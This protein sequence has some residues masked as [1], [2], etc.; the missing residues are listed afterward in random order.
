MDFSWVGPVA[1][2]GVGGLFA[3]LAALSTNS[4]ALRM[5]KR[6]EARADRENL[7]SRAMDVL[8][9]I[10][11]F[12]ERRADAVGDRKLQHD[13]SIAVLL[14]PDTRLR[15]ALMS[16]EDAFWNADV[17]RV[18]ADDDEFRPAQTTRQAVRYGKRAAAA[19]VR[20]DSDTE[21]I[22]WLEGLDDT[23]LQAFAQM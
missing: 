21:A 3:W 19:A 5:A 15:S 17:L 16:M 2:A 13:L 6:E 20:G 14:M 18:I 11:A 22:E 9:L 10:N 7:R 4:M 1:G 12:D 8:K 23:F